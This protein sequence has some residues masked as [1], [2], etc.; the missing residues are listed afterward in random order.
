MLKWW[1]VKQLLLTFVVLRFQLK[2]HWHEW[3]HFLPLSKLFCF[4]TH[5]DDIPFIPTW[6]VLVATR[7]A[8]NVIFKKWMEVMI[9][10]NLICHG[11]WFNTP[12]WQ[13]LCLL[14]FREWC[15]RPN[16]LI[17]WNKKASYVKAGSLYSAKERVQ[18][19]KILLTVF[20]SF[21]VNAGEV[22]LLYQTILRVVFS[23][24][25]WLFSLRT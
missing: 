12:G 18:L 23:T 9:L 1:T 24:L 7:S 15:L 8:G 2:T 10:K 25:C 22:T 11:N 16:K 3:G 5:K 20:L 6:K 17:H 19:K 4:H 14:C 13:G 21:Q